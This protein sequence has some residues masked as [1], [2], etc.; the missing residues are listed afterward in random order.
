MT[1]QSILLFIEHYLPGYKFGGPIQSVANL[2]SLLRE[3]YQLSIVTRDRDFRETVAYPGIPTNQWLMKDGYQI[4]YLSPAH[5]G[6]R[7]I[8][9]LLDER[10]YTYIYTNSLFASF[11]R[12]LLLLSF[13][14]GKQIVIAPRGEL[15]PG[16]IQLKSYK[17]KPFVWLT[18]WLPKDRVIWHATDKEE[19]LAIRHHF[20]DWRVQYAPIRYAPDTPRRLKQRL[21]YT[22]KKGIARLVFISRITRKKGLH[23]LLDLLTRYRSS[24]ITLDIYGPIVDKVYWA[25]CEALL[26][27]MPDSC[28]VTN[29]GSLSHELVNDT[30]IDYDFFVLPTAGENF[31]HAIFEALSAG[32]PVLISDQTPWLGLENRCAGWDLPLDQANWEQALTESVEMDNLTYSQW[33]IQAVN[34]AN[35]YIRDGQFEL[36]YLSLFS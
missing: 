15:H 36:S 6:I 29:R 17:K 23:F 3:H 1:K 21:A 16:A 12:Q 19:L 28:R 2:V 7:H 30:L 22:K 13:W 31:G 33:S 27:R 25:E 4:M 20:V 24:Q 35:A 11:T 18:R 34:V 5:T 9:A 14:T 8:K 32:I 26:S 10:N